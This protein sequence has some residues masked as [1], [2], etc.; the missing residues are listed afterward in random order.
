MKESLSEDCA[1]SLKPHFCSKAAKRSKSRSFVKSKTTRKWFGC[2][3]RTE[4]LTR[5]VCF[6]IEIVSSGRHSR[7]HSLSL[8]WLRVRS[9]RANRVGDS[10]LSFLRHGRPRCSH[11]LKLRYRS[12]LSSGGSRGRH[13]GQID[14]K[15]PAGHIALR[16]APEGGSKLRRV[17]WKPLHWLG[18]CCCRRNESK[19]ASVEV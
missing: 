17:C 11:S 12:A 8:T 19:E 2:S 5:L 7:S 18:P 15:D 9:N 14:P 3:E 1:L 13:R 16:R 4:I 6:S 10:P